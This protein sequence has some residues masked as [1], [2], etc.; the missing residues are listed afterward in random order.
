MKIKSTVILLVVLFSTT[1]YAE[2]P[3]IDCI[4][5]A[6]NNLA[7]CVADA[8]TEVQKKVCPK[9]FKKAFKKCSEGVCK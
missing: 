2:C 7:T 1:V 8:K 9:I 5:S 6:R 4:K 3:C